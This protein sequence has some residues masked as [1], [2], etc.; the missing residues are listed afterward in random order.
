MLSLV[1]VLELLLNVTSVEKNLNQN[2][3]YTMKSKICGL[4]STLLV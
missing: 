2:N 3:S 4:Q 1:G